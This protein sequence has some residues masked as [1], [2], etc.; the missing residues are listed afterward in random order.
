MKKLFTLI[1]LMAMTLSVQA[2][3]EEGDFLIQP[4][5]GM[6]VSNVSDGDKWKVNFTGGVEIEHFINDV[7]SLS[8][9][10]MYTRQGCIYNG[11]N[12]GKTVD[13]DVTLNLQYGSI[14][15]MASYYVL[16]GLA[17]KAGIQPAFRLKATVEQGGTRID[18]DKAINLLFYGTDVKLNKFDLSI[19]VGL[20]YEISNITLDA[21]YNIG[22]TNLTKGAD[23]TRNSVFVFTLGYKIGR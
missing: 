3:H 9:G 8:A 13:D 15:L 6:T 20:S 10:L 16:P 1:A 21:R 23:T 22:V 2:Q 18:L 7:F 5:V 17:L 4:R 19:P 11:F 12:D 14:P